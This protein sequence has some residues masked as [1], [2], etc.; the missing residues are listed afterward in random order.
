MVAHGPGSSLMPLTQHA[1][2][3][4]AIPVPGIGDHATAI[5]LFAG[6]V[7][8][9]FR[10]ERTGKGCHVSTSLIAEGAWATAAWLQAALAGAKFSGLIDRTK[11][12]NALAA[13]YQ[14]SDRRWLLLAFV[15]E[16]K[17]W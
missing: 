1:S 13:S 11:P 9:L 2:R 10:R 17:N 15:E 6:I 8:G 3:R 12:P 4:P 5:S 7:T 14:T 16:D